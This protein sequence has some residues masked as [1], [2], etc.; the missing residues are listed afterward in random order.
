MVRAATASVSFAVIVTVP[1]SFLPK[2]KML[3]VVASKV[4]LFW[5]VKAPPNVADPAIV[6]TPADVSLLAE[7]KNCISPIPPPP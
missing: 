3:L 2:V 7:E 4:S 1:A 6:S 5:R